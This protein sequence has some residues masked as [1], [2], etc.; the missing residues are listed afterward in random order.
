[1]LFTVLMR[2][3]PSVGDLC[4][5]F[6]AGHIATALDD[7]FMVQQNDSGAVAHYQ[8]VE[9]RF[10]QAPVGF[11]GHVVGWVATEHL[12][13]ASKV[14]SVMKTLDKCAIVSTEASIAATLQLLGQHGFVFTA[15]EKG[16]SGFIAPSDLDRHAARSY[17]Y[18]LISGIE[19]ILSKIV[20][21][22][23]PVASIINAMSP[24]MAERYTEAYGAGREANPVEYLYLEELVNLFLESTYVTDSR[25]W[26]ES[27]TS[28]LTEMN[29]FRSV[30]MHPTRS[31]VMARSS[32][33]LAALARD[34]NVLLTR[35]QMITD[36]LY[37]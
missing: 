6:H 18:L 33:Q 28:R 4:G 32:A 25:V 34:S 20:G 23:T 11:Q 5:V 35:L 7:A 24:Q 31:F 3:E 14:K 8:L 19:M 1:M 27:C 9:Q 10:D 21:S 15:G 13:D 37:S 29:K 16:L 22:I 12:R 2:T 30:I 36:G 17:F 26:D